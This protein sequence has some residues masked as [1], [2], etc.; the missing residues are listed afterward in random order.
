[1]F[2][3]YERYYSELNER[4]IR[5]D[6]SLAWSFQY[7]PSLHEW[8][9]AL[10]QVRDAQRADVREIFANR[11]APSSTI[12]ASR[13]LRVVAVWWWVLPIVHIPRVIGAAVSFAL[14]I[15]GCW[16]LFRAGL[17]EDTGIAPT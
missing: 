2:C 17:P 10:R 11:G 15:C 4:G 3:F 12:S 7:A 6:D 5:T 9:A 8:P 16:I 13:A 1:V 14:V